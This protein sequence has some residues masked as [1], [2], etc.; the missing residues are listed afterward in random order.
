MAVYWA[1]ERLQ[2]DGKTKLALVLR[3]TLMAAYSYAAI[4]N[5]HLIHNT[6]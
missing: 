3:I 4:H 5:T 1:T 2:R 6:P